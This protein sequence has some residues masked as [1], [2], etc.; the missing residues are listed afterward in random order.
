MKLGSKLLKIIYT[1]ADV[2]TNKLEE[3]Q[4]IIQQEDADIVAITE[5]LPK[6]MIFPVEE[7]EFELQGYQFVSNIQIA[8]S[9]GGRGIC[10][11]I[12]EGLHVKRRESCGSFMEDLFADVV[13]H[14]GKKISVGLIY[15][16]P[17]SSGTNNL[18]LLDSIRRFANNTGNRMIIIG[19][20]NLPKIK[21]S[22]F[23]AN[24]CSFEEQFLDCIL[25][26]YLFQHIQ[27]ITKT[28]TGQDGST[29]DLVLTK[30]EDYINDI[31]F[32]IPL[33]KGDHLLMSITINE[34]IYQVESVPRT[35][36]L[37]YKG[38]YVAIKDNLSKINWVKE[39]N[40][41]SVEECWDTLKNKL[42]VCKKNIFQ[43]QNL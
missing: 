36:Y 34:P 10:F 37:M 1:N 33:G 8:K 15:R 38:D 14:S 9:K 24:P 22:D 2:L 25:D 42:L 39:F 32:K 5:V 4:S 35:R 28:R 19:D 40:G 23:Q 21:W 11:Y 30:E 27:E 6:N 16:S 43:L 31:I 17:N 20:F 18:K 12:K 13:L 29:L 26:N 3:L 7:F 41:K